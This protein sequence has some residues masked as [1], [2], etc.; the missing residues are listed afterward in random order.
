LPVPQG[1]TNAPIGA[2]FVIW[3]GIAK[4]CQEANRRLISLLTATS[5]YL[6]IFVW[7]TPKIA[8]FCDLFAVHEQLP[9]P[10]FLKFTASHI[11]LK[12]GEIRFINQWNG[13]PK[14]YI[15]TEMKKT[16]F[17]NRVFC[18]F[19]TVFCY[20]FLLAITVSTFNTCFDRLNMIDAINYPMDE[21]LMY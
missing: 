9:Q 20:F 19:K 5:P 8:N 14:T 11:R 15:L 12:F 3:Q 6:G 17:L 7:K 2:K 16:S 4:P 18:C 21:Y 1:R 13:I 10:I